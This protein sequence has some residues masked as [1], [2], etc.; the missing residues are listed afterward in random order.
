MEVMLTLGHIP[1]KKT[2]VVSWLVSEATAAPRSG[3]YFGAKQTVQELIGMKEFEA[4]F[5]KQ[6]S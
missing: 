5:V 6:T 3:S 1:S 4:V 2:D